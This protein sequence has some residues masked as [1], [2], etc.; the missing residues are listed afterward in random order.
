MLTRPWNLITVLTGCLFTLAL[1]PAEA[2]AAREMRPTADFQ[3]IAASGAFEVQVRQGDKTQVEVEGDD[4]SVAHLETVVESSASG[5]VLQ[6]RMKP[7]WSSRKLNAALT[8]RVTTPRLVSVALR[9]S[10]ALKLEPF[11]T[12]ELSLAV[13]G[14]GDAQL[15]GL[16][17][18]RLSVS[19]SGSGDVRGDGRSTALKLAIAGSGDARLSELQADAVEVRIAG[20]GDAQVRAEKTLAVS[21]AGSGDVRYLGAPELRSS[22]AGSGSVK[23]LR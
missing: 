23:S 2:W 8:V 18:E 5:P 12:P 3:A 20:S 17:S 1:L 14:S 7:G 9:G 11:K 21:I 10:G 16:Q 6:L 22:I 13:S 4:D 15:K 19:I